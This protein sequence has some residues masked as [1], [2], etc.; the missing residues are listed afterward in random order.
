M[1]FQLNKRY[2][3]YNSFSFRN[4]TH[5]HTYKIKSY[6]N[7]NVMQKSFPFQMTCLSI[8]KNYFKNDILL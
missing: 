1:F 4:G 5:T 3:H 7:K 6:S 2:T 8:L